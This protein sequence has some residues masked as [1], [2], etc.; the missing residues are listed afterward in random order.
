MATH[1]REILRSVRQVEIRSR[2]LVTDA[3]VGA[4]HSVFKGRGMDFEEVREYLPGDDVRNIDWN[5]TARMD[6][7][8][9]KV[10]REE[11]ELTLILAVDMSASGWFGTAGV[12]KR[13]RAAE[14]AAV[15]ALSAV[16]NQD[17]VGL[18][19]FS[20]QIER[21]VPPRKGRS[22]VL[23]VVRDILFHEPAGRGT[24]LAE[25][26]DHLGRIQRRR[27]IV[28]LLSDFLV[29]ELEPDTHSDRPAAE[30]LQRALRVCGR[31]HDLVAARLVDPRE[32]ALPDIGPL[33]LEDA[34]TGEVIEIDPRRPDLRHRY[35]AAARRRAEFTAQIF[36]E[37]GIDALRIPTDGPY[38]QALRR[39]F[40]QREAR[41]TS[42]APR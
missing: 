33:V 6:R 14:L 13:E 18:L 19:L 24:H 4:Y 35:A 34:E 15:L 41:I 37:A 2:R 40:A 20:D 39:F 38:L 31:R 25:A 5:V 8:F 27:A 30:R 12:T 32:E 17:K 36:R 22:H 42:N 7:P 1:P 3:L 26:L 10:F 9:V 29:P 11:R 21:W 23:R 16:R 28:F